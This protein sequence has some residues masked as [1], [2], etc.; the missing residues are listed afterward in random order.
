MKSIIFLP[1]LNQQINFLLNRI[2]LLDLTCLV[3]GS[4]SEEVAKII[5]HESQKSVEIIVEDYDSLM[6][7]KFSLNSEN[8]IS[9]KMMAYDATDYSNEKFDLIYAQGSV[10]DKRRKNITKE[11]KRILK[12]SGYFCLGEIVKL[13]NQ[14]PTFVSELFERSNIDP[15]EKNNF[16][17]YFLERK[18]ELIDSI[19]L[20]ASLKEYYKNN[21]KLLAEKVK[22]LSSNEKSYY[23]KLVNQIKHES[24]AYINLGADKY[25]GF[26]AML[27]KKI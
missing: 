24:N 19:D 23:K 8:S 26:H 17:K 15:L 12:P 5:Q 13:E 21:L 10:T 18:F 7:S 1:G 3:I 16:Q 14:I 9:V 20:S 6:N 27:L 22:T 25:F 2:N 4:N 11:I